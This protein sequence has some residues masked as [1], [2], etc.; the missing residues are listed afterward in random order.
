[1]GLALFDT[2]AALL[3]WQLR[4][5]G[6]GSAGGL[7]LDPLACGQAAVQPDSV[8]V[9]TSVEDSAPVAADATAT[10]REAWNLKASPDPL[11]ALIQMSRPTLRLAG[12][13]EISVRVLGGLSV[14]LKSLF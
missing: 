3:R 10:G 11:V 2:F 5:H 13:P 6:A 9:V 8:S 7:Q 14:T 4:W 1:M 12:G